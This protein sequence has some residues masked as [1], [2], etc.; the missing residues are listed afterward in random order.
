VH[1][2]GENVHVIGNGQQELELTGDGGPKRE[3]IME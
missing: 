2:T 3:R 1:Q